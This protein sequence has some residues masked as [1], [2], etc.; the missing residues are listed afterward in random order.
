MLLVPK[1]SF[2][3]TNG[4]FIG[5]YG[6][7]VSGANLAIAIGDRWIHFNGTNLDPIDGDTLYTITTQ[8]ERSFGMVPMAT[9]DYGNN[10]DSIVTIATVAPMA[11]VVS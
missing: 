4:C 2:S 8:I 7:V 11:T 1:D 3:G 9:M 5:A 10:G 6:D